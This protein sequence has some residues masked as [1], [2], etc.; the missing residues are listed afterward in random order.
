MKR[1]LVVRN[2]K[3]GDFMLAWPSFA[4]LKRA[5]PVHVTALVPTYTAPLATLCPW[6]DEV[7][8]DPG[9]N[10][11]KDQQRALIARL[12]SAGFDASICLF[13][14]ARNAMLMWK[15]KIPYRLAPAT[16]WAQILYN[17][18]LVQRRSRSL[19]AES[20]YNLDLIRYFLTQ[21]GVAAIEE[22]T[23]PY[24]SFQPTQLAKVRA[25]LARELKI[26]ASRPWLIVHAG[27]GGSA[28]NLSIE[29]YARTIIKLNRIYPQ[30]QCLLTAGPGEESAT[31]ELAIELLAH[32]GSSWI[33]YSTEGLVTFCQVIA[34]AALFMAGSTGPLHIA[35]ALDVPTIGF[36]PMR[37]SATP[38]RWRPL[39]SKGRHLA[40]SPSAQSDNPEDMSQLEPAYLV[41]QM[42]EWVAPFVLS[43]T[44]IDNECT[45][46]C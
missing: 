13:S 38:L 45:S 21:Q 34:N 33:Y 18:R 7:I 23:A 17:H 30:L 46:T 32:G 1:I 3:I 26:D 12:R 15:A 8:I 27:S 2:D 35:G 25:K 19:K 20:E 5:M 4:M 6:I 22:P 39:N 29:Q 36:F 11:D 16:K 24:L 14:N 37:R 43:S 28:N 10:G 9:I 41:A 31:K 44:G 42:T 40:L